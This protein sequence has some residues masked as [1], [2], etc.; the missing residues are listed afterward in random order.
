M[1]KITP[2]I[3][4]GIIL[5]AAI[6]LI[7]TGDN[8]KK[9]VL[10]ERI[11]FRKKDKIPY[12]TYVAYEG[13]KSLFPGAA[14]STNSNSPG[15]WDSLS[16][17]DDRQA[18]IVV[19]PVF[20]ADDFEMKKIV[21]FVE[22]GNDVFISAAFVS[23]EVKAVMN[24]GISYMD[25]YDV[26]SGKKAEEDTLQVALANPPFHRSYNYSY[27]G[28]KLDCHFFKIDSSITTVLGN[29]QEGNTNFIHLKAG[30]GNL[31]FHLA[32]MAF[33]N[34]FLLR[35]RNMGYYE[36]VLSVISPTTR[37]I[38]WD[39]YFLTKRDMSDDRSNQRDGKGWLSALLSYPALKWAL[40]VAII[41][42]LL[43]V[44]LEM[45][46][47]QRF[48]PVIT[49]PRNDSLDF[50]KTIGRLYY[51]KGD[52]KN[53]CRKMSAYFLEHVRNRYKLSTVEMNE[54]FIKNLQ[55][56]TGADELELRSIVFFI[57][58]LETMPAVSEHQLAYFHK[59]LE[60]FYSKI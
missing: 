17:Y 5:A 15:N 7:F 51:D 58:D 48:I 32:P 14:V 49:K 10:D 35:D 9:R 22:N 2:Y 11:S 54:D 39:E 8:E 44:L 21:R 37:T 36:D 16:N 30:K 60:S 52:H 59:Q 19:S 41:T 55:F 29:N 27:P 4:A 57:K 45:R 34:Y 3:L 42:L 18:L 50:V 47:K 6:V 26:F 56:K 53:L 25:I 38:V 20:Y 46:R 40:L 28:K 13:L 33:T 31:F 23:E 24:C 1:K 43:Y 12:G